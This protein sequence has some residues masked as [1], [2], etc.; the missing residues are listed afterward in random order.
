[1]S[2]SPFASHVVFMLGPVPVTMTV[3]V[4]W[5]IMAL[6]VAAGLAW[7]DRQVVAA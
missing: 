6:L 2:E 3:V 5:A 4:T 7:R 1:M